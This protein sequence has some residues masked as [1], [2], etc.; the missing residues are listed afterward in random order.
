MK[1][2]GVIEKIPAFHPALPGYHGRD[3]WKCGD[4]EAECTGIVTALVPSVSVIRQ[5][6]EICASSM[7]R[8]F[9]PSRA[10]RAGLRTFPTR[11]YGEK[12]KLLDTV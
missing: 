3:D 10:A 9:T 12:R 1:N 8:P 4:T 6:I 2:R 11:F 7:S 5:A